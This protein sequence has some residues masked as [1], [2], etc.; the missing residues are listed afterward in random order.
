MLK[1]EEL[2]RQSFEDIMKNALYQIPKLYPKWTNFNPSDPGITILE[3]MA[4]LT[5]VQQYHL[6]VIRYEHKLRYLKLLGT[7]PKKAQPAETYLKISAQ[8]RMIPQGTVYFADDI[9]FETLYAFT[10]TDNEI[11]A[12]END[13]SRIAN[14]SNMLNDMLFY[15]FGYEKSCSTFR[16]CLK[17]QPEIGTI[18]SFYFAVKPVEDCGSITKDFKGFVELGISDCGEIISDETCGFSKS[19]TICI[20]IKKHIQKQKD[21]YF[22]EFSVLSG[23]YPIKPILSQ[24]VCNVVPA[25]QKRTY[26]LLSEGIP[27]RKLGRAIGVC[28]FSIPCEIEHILPQTLKIGIQES[29]GFYQ[30]ERVDDFDNS[31]PNSRHFIFAKD[32]LIF[33]DGEKGMPPEGEIYLLGCAVSLDALGNIKAGAMDY[34]DGSTESRAV[35]ITPSTGG[36]TE[37]TIDACFVRACENQDEPK[38]CVT[39]KDFEQAVRSVPGVP[40]HRVKA[41][42]NERIENC[43]TIAVENIKGSDRLNECCLDHM[44]RYIIPKLMVGTRLEFTAPEYTCIYIYAELVPN[45]RDNITQ[46]TEELIEAFFENINFGGTISINSLNKYICRTK[47]IDSVKSLDVSYSGGSAITLENGDIQLKKSSLPKLKYISLSWSGR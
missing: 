1:S 9:P 36:K 27:E 2:D 5:E 22:I 21:N 31:T 4:W 13:I 32:K 11:T 47:W 30:W 39:L 18:M 42:L 8:N 20:K 43:I 14:D 35:N 16:L 24:A 17:K 3:L 7:A 15:P 29:D 44:R 19:G 46:Q 37:E 26:P 23:E 34:F 38:R 40:I 45:R 41:F 28:N 25:V 6:N 33:G 12:V 10:A